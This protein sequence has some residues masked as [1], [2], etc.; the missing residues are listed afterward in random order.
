M[1]DKK[2]ELLAILNRE[3]GRNFRVLPSTGMAKLMKS[4]TPDEISMALH[5][6]CRDGWHAGK[7]KELSS[8]YLLRATTIDK[9]LQ[10][11]QRSP[12]ANTLN[13]EPLVSI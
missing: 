5:A 8:E 9:W 10:V 1:E 7:I 12:K 6:L 13:P 4:F 2:D 3:T 11:A